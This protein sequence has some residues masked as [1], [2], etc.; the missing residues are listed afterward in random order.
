M[1]KNKEQIAVNK[2]WL[3]PKEVKDIYGLS[4]STLAKWRME[5]KYLSFSKVGKYI[6]YKRRDIENF[7]IKNIVEAV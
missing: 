4:T 5:N 6:K 1:E 7:L 2:D 3:N